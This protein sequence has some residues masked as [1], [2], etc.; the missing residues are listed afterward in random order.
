MKCGIE[1]VVFVLYEEGLICEEVK[2]S[3]STTK[4]VNNLESNL[5]CDEGV[6]EK[7]L[8]VLEKKG[9][10]LMVRK[11]RTSLKNEL[12]PF[13]P[14]G[15][16]P[17][18]RS[19]SCAGLSSRQWIQPEPRSASGPVR[20]LPSAN[21]QQPSLG[22]PG[23]NTPELASKKLSAFSDSALESEGASFAKMQEYEEHSY[24][25][26]Q[27]ELNA[28]EMDTSYRMERVSQVYSTVPW[29]G[30]EHGRMGISSRQGTVP[31]FP[32]QASED[33]E[34]HSTQETPATSDPQPFEIVPGITLNEISAAHR[35]EKKKLQYQLNIAQKL[36]GNLSIQNVE[37]RSVIRQNH[38]EMRSL[39]QRIEKLEEEKDNLQRALDETNV[40][41]GREKKEAQHLQE[42]LTSVK[43]HVDRLIIE[44][45]KQEKLWRQDDHVQLE[46]KQRD[47]AAKKTEMERKDRVIENLLNQ[48]DRLQDQLNQHDQEIMR[49]KEEAKSKL[50]KATQERTRK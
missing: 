48:N 32:M 19:A 28:T 8:L 11:L 50:L 31:P 27:D 41:Y 18:L 34:H 33:I 20:P 12:A 45:D 44:K 29:S 30:R 49:L 15:H 36:V 46:E 17:T 21:S 10:D 23:V 9:E 43:Q 16:P 39:V 5:S 38:Q 6:W 25:Y 13:V 3:G 2:S 47:L 7:L 42:E 24:S 14:N 40:A 1:S 26:L 35:G 22:N 4:I 37:L